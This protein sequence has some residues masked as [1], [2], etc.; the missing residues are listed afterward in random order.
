MQVFGKTYPPTKRVINKIILIK[1]YLLMRLD[2]MDIPKINIVDAKD[3]GSIDKLFRYK[4]F[5]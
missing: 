5:K 3:T 2:I 4:L 1:N